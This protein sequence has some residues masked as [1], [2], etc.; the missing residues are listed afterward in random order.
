MIDADHKAARAPRRRAGATLAMRRPGWATWALAIAVLLL[1]AFTLLLV[2]TALGQSMG[3][4]PLS[5]PLVILDARLPLVFR[6]HMFSAAI[7]L[8][9]IPAVVLLRGRPQWHR[10][11]GRLAAAFVVIGGVTALPSAILSE[12]TP[13]ARAGL[14]TQG[15]VWLALIV[16]GFRAIRA[17]NVSRHVTLMLTM[18]AVG[19]GAIWLRPLLAAVVALDLPYDFAYSVLAWAVWLVPTGLLLWLRHRYKTTKL[20]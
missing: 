12:A 2:L 15:L 9:L 18:A 10:P 19:S 8:G 5:W 1:T 7:A 16:A 13:A 20:S 4:V 14:F 11:L 17:R 3:I 6:L